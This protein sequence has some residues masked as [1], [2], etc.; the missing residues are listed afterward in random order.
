MR[1]AATAS[2]ALALLGPAI[3]E[4]GVS[5]A[6]VRKEADPGTSFDIDKVVTTPQI[7]P[8]PDVVLLVDVTGSMGGA[9]DNIKENLRHIITTVKDAQANAQFAVVSFGDLNDANGGFEVL[10]K[11][12]D[13]IPDLQAAVDK[14]HPIGG[15]DWDEDWINALYQVATG[16]IAYRSGS[17][18]IVVLIGDAPSHDPSGGHNLG[19]AID[20]LKHESIRVVA[21][22]VDGLDDRQQ[23]T[24]VTTATGG[25]IVRPSP[26]DEVS[27]AIV[28]G[29]K[30]LDVTVKPDI[31]C[32]AGIGVDISPPEI[33][34]SSG[35][36]VTFLETAKVSD[37]AT[38]GD[39]ID[40]SVRFL[41]NG[42]SGGDAF[43]QNITVPVNR[44]GCDLCDPK[45]GK[46]K[47]HIT[48][49]CA[50]TPYGT[51]CL[52]RPG[53]KADG[54]NDDDVKSQWRMTWS[55]GGHE[56]RVG[57]KPGIKADTLCDSKNKG[58]DVCKEVVVARC[59]KPKQVL[60]LADSE[61]V[62]M[63]DGDL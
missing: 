33:T 63:G 7:P 57:V 60:D 1:F 10:Q 23:A 52:T 19:E 16:A 40:C 51:M 37:D 21:V 26:S 54:V 55:S 48:T 35:S 32:D 20:A 44:L 30:N 2:L 45:P 27:N 39:T 61:Q 5:P 43:V 50:P 6:A 42:E 22:N 15:G 8:T 34:V 56:H 11:L 3:A 31:S 29:L 13:S 41:L 17:S 53:Y 38:Q 9:L 12:T 59:A 58:K 36:T 62:V 25:K 49:S 24:E 4:P 14:L 18:R 28:D 46:N 47:C